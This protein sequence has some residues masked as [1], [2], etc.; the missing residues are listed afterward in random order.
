MVLRASSLRLAGSYDGALALSR[1]HTG[2][3]LT[4][5]ARFI[6]ARALVDR[7]TGHG[8]AGGAGSSKRPTRIDVQSAEVRV[9]DRVTLDQVSIAGESGGASNGRIDIAARGEGRGAMSLSFYPQGSTTAVQGRFDDVAGAARTFLGLDSLRG[10]AATLRGT[11]QPGGADLQVAMSDVRVTG[12]PLLA[13]I[14]TMGSLQGM[15]N[16]LNGGGIQFAHVVAP[17]K[18]RGSKLYIG[19]ARAT[20]SAL[21]LTA[22]GVV[23]LHRRIVDLNG[24]IAPAYALNGL[25]GS[26]PV[27][28]D[29]LVSKKGE[30]V[31]GLTYSARGAFASPRVS[32]NPLALA[33]PG[34]LRRMFEGHSAGAPSGGGPVAGAN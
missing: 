14:L 23:D 12:A 30:G 22:S 8:E 16:N 17:L 4:G 3:T 5:R 2:D 9:S 32:V 11:L 13:R 21:G 27:L 29:L 18:L 1:D 25:V 10:G 26:V 33:A 20:G 31:F 7:V 28:G 15:A 19:E 24:G 6:D 34:I